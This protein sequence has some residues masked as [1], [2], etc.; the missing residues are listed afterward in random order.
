MIMLAKVRQSWIERRESIIMK[1]LRNL[2]PGVD[3]NEAPVYF[4]KPGHIVVP[5]L[6]G[7]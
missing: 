6:A 5:G 7:Q 4:I 1:S 2:I 3:V